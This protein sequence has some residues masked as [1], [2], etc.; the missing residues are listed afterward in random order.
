ME[1]RF[2]QRPIPRQ[3]PNGVSEDD[4]INSAMQA[5]KSALAILI[6]RLLLQVCFKGSMNDLW[7]LFFT[8][9]LIAY[10]TI[11]DVKFPANAEIYIKE[12]VKLVEFD[13]LKPT[14][15][16]QT[17]FDPTFKFSTWIKDEPQSIEIDKD[18]EVSMVDDLIFY[19]MCLALGLVGLCLL[20]T[21]S[22]FKKLRAKLW[23]ILVNT[24][25]FL[26]FSGII[27][28]VLIVYLMTLVKA[29]I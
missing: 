10:L 21:F 25:D 22:A 13:I 6:V 14:V 11:Y 26:F 19:A 28:S 12:F 1:R 27:R 3:L 5:Q 9:Q 16:I 2:I 20:L 24:L 7:N 18:Q 4:I 23:G 17:F 15:F 29:S 8:I